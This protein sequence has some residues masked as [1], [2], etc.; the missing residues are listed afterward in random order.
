[1]SN[2]AKKYSTVHYKNY[3]D[4]K[5]LLNA[6]HLRSAEL[7]DEPAHEEMLFI[8]VH[9]AYELWFKQIIHELTSIIDLFQKD[10]IDERNIGV[11]V[12]LFGT[13]CRNSK[14]TY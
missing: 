6:Q 10:K 5:R 12:S 3:L 7:N 2:E 14:V 9:Q 13:N 8:I 1:M 11:A 4:L